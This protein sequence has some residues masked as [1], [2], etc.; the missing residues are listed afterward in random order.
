MKRII[1]I[2]IVVL[3]ALSASCTDF[4]KLN[5]NPST[6]PDMDPTLIIPTVQM[7]QS[8]NHQEWARYLAYPGGFMDY[9]GGN[10]S[11]V[12]YG[13]YGQKYDNYMSQ[14][15][16]S[17]YPVILRDIIDVIYRTTE[18]ETLVN[19]NSIARILKVQCFHKVTDTY[20][21][22][23]YFDAGAG[24]TELIFTP[25]YDKQE[26]I[27]YDMLKELKEAAEALDP[28]VMKTVDNDFYYGG[29]LE[30]WRKFANSLRLRLAM[31]LTK[32]NPERAKKE[33]E[34]AYSS[35]V[36]ESNADICFMKHEDY[37]NPSGGG[38]KGN[39]LALRL[40]N[41]EDPKENSFRI[42][43]EYVQ[44]LE[45]T[46]DPRLLYCARAYLNDNARTDITAIVREHKA[47]YAEM[48]LP[49][50]TFGWDGAIWEQ[51]LVVE[52]NGVEVS[53]AHNQQR[54]QPSK[55]ITTPD[56]PF[57]HLSYAEVKYLLAEAAHR[58]WNVGSKGAEEH[59]AEGLEAA[60]R[61]WS[62]YGITVDES[63]L[64]TFLNFNQLQA[65]EELEQINTQIWVLHLL[66]PQEGWA[67]WRR[68]GIPE[69]EYVMREPNLN[70][71]E[72]QFPRRLEYP[73][74]EHTKNGQNYQDAVSR[75]AGGKDSWIA[76]VWW[77]K[78]L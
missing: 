61:Q 58:G 55:T 18:D 33:V 51:A 78:E 68:T 23:P 2:T 12:N 73:I 19:V 21:D 30:K 28:A 53:L 29:D 38:G 74:E 50:Q 60:V 72:G 56:A 44:Y 6:S 71:T 76:R 47:S 14:V 57:I 13:G 42:A 8:E 41:L 64:D 5:Q 24:A 49:S 35:G 46:R 26:D 37:I 15:W 70:Q 22:V 45:N 3:L 77:D 67:N 20:G 59:F 34:E 43:Q 48:A 54:L 62:L 40:S 66:N 32:V 75:I 1:H 36:F 17:Y 9:W 16:D 65:G 11:V 63:A 25:V 4:D 10:W 69:M 39:G 27:Y 31:R 52:I 7:R